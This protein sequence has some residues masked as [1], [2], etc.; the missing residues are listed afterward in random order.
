MKFIKYLLLLLSFS[1]AANIS[2][3]KGE[4]P[5][6][7][8][9]EAT[10]Y[11]KVGYTDITITYCRPGVKERTIW[12][13]LVPYNEIWRTGANEATT[14]EFSKDVKIEGHNVPAGKYS[15]FTIPSENEWTVIINKHW[16]QWGAFNYNE[17]E[18]LIRFKVKPVKNDFT[19]RLLFTFDYVSPYF[20]KVV[21][22][23]EKLKISFTI[24][25]A[26]E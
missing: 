24:E 1:I 14:I 20:A 17:A 25:A 7:L 15:L 22:E 12:G 3:K 2:A 21:F 11:E 8:S 4:D 10:V 6:R 23:W 26:N 13:S 16:D 9:P 19:E 18:D 5:P